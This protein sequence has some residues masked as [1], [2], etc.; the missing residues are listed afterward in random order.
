MVNKANIVKDIYRNLSGTSI[1]NEPKEGALY[2]LGIL[3]NVSRP[4][5]PK[6]NTFLKL[7]F[8]V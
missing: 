3:L 4:E 6:K 7:T 2:L 8:S 1:H 5:K